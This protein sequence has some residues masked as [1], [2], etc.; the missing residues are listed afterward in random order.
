MGVFT[1]WGNLKKVFQ[2]VVL[3]SGIKPT[4]TLTRAQNQAVSLCLD[5]IFFGNFS[6]MNK[7]LNIFSRNIFLIYANSW[8]VKVNRTQKKKKNPIKQNN[9]FDL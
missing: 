9:E 8:G 7:P 4:Q 2:P 6:A 5:Y 1:F 3:R